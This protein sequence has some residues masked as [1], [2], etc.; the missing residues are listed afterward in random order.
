MTLGPIPV[1]LLQFSTL[2]ELDID[3]TAM[4]ISFSIH[5][6]SLHFPFTTFTD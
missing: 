2:S 6:I 5:Y 4:G 1:N 3:K